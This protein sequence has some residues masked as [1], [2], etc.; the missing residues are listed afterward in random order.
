MPGKKAKGARLV[1][2]AKRKV[3]QVKNRKV[4]KQHSRTHNPDLYDK[5]NMKKFKDGGIIQHD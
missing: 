3:S 4:E 5:P 1:D 2:K